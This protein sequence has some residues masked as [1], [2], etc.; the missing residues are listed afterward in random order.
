MTAENSPI[1]FM[2]AAAR[3]TRFL[4]QLTRDTSLTCGPLG[5]GSRSSRVR[6]ERADGSVGS[7][8]A[9]S[10]EVCGRPTPAAWPEGGALWTTTL[11]TGSCS[12]PQE[13]QNRA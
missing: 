5:P 12:V 2:A 7:G 13:G 6:A 4:N 3:P 1:T 8:G 11:L 10:N 9:A